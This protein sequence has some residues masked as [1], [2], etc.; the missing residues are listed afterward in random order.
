MH[1]QGASRVEEMEIGVQACGVSEL[2]KSRKRDVTTSVRAHDRNTHY[3]GTPIFHL[4][5]N[6]CEAKVI[7]AFLLHCSWCH[8][9]FPIDLLPTN[10]GMN[11]FSMHAFVTD[12]L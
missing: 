1:L 6:P 10:A 4:A 12:T 7:P 9:F 8:E 5:R 3:L 2:G 11:T